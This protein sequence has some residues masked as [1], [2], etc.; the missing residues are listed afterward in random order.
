M[1][2]RIPKAAKP[3]ISRQATYFTSADLPLL[4][5]EHTID[6]QCIADTTLSESTRR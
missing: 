4:P 6:V 3:V 2:Y 5:H 1:F